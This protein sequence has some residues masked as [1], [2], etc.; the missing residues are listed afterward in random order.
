MW[1]IL[2]IYIVLWRVL[3][4][5]LMYCRNNKYTKHGKEKMGFMYTWLQVWRV[6]TK[7]NFSGLWMDTHSCRNYTLILMTSLILSNII[8]GT[9]AAHKELPR[10]DSKAEETHP[11]VSV[12]DTGVASYLCHPIVSC[13]GQNYISFNQNGGGILERTQPV[14]LCFQPFC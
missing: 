13:N 8:V 14:S 1:S 6:R 4:N 5:V 7:P 2:N 9:S 11:R 3:K 12:T 10:D